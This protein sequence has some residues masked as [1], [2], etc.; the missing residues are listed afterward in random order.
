MHIL[1]DPLCDP[2]NYFFLICNI[3]IITLL[4]LCSL[5]LYIK[6]FLA[7][8]I[9]FIIFFKSIN[10]YIETFK[11]SSSFNPKRIDKQNKKKT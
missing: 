4:N 9:F 8:N 1:N 3:V 6:V 5:C 10:K 7:K 2:C 11:V